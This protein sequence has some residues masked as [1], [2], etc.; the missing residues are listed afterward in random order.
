LPGKVR[1][2]ASWR[3]RLHSSDRIKVKIQAEIIHT[4]MDSLITI[5]TPESTLG[6]V[7][8]SAEKWLATI[9]EERRRLQEDQDGLRER[10]TNLREYEARLRS[11]QAE[12]DASHLA[13]INYQTMAPPASASNATRPPSGTPF[14][15]DPSLPTP[16]EKFQRAREIFEAEQKNLREDRVA[17]H[18]QEAQIKRRAES[19][20]VREAEIAKRE[21]TLVTA[22]T[23]QPKP[24]NP[25][26]VAAKKMF[27]RRKR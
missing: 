1:V 17:L 15:S 26:P 23:T 25:E 5:P 14:T 3:Y 10:E 19:V 20:A 9:T 7:F 18:E 22:T 2:K 27:G 6:S 13:L 8:P 16:W 21:A 12:I 24:G 11:L 4:S